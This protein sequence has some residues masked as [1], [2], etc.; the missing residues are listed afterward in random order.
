MLSKEQLIKSMLFEIRIIKHLGT[1]LQPGK[2]SWRPTPGQRSMLELMQYLTTCGIVP[3]LAAIK[4][5]W[6]DAEALEKA[7]EGV[8]HINFAD[9]MDAQGRKLRE[10]IH[11]IPHAD[12][13]HK[14]T[15]TPWGA[16]CKVGE[17]LVNMA[18][19]PLV[20]YRMQFFL[21]LKEAG[22]HD[23]GPAQCWVGVDPQPQKAE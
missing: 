5:N 23:L 13:L 9:A 4:D 8:N 14:D 3:A 15:R 7:A 1:K 18:L 22:R 10:A 21:Y 11:A 19:K 2:L 16:P 20:A 12:L 17:A 6:D